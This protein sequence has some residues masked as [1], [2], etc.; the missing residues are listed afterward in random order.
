[1]RND[2]SLTLDQ[3]KARW[4]EVLDS[5]LEIDRVLWLSFFDARLVSYSQETLTL[6]YVDANKM[7]GD[8]NFKSHRKPEQV[9]QLRQ[10]I[11]KIF[12]ERITITEL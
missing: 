10:A 12:G 7:S 9:D 6:D 8:H 4:N 11:E 3:I 2:S 5:L 1:M